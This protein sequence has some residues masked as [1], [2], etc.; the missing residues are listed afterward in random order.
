MR[1]RIV[2]ALVLALVFFLARGASAQVNAEALRSTLRTNP[3]FLWLQSA[4]NGNAGNT[5]TI[6]YSGAAFG[7]LTAVPHLAF[8]RAAVDFG[9][10]SGTTNIA[11]MMAHARYNYD[12]TE[13]IALEALAQVQRDRF[14][15][16]SLRDLYGGGLR[17]ALYRSKENEVFSGTTYL[18]EH[19]IIGDVPGSEGNN[20]I[21]HRS[22]DYFGVNLSLT[23]IVTASSVIYAQPR[24]DRPLDFRIL[25][26]TVVTFTITK[27]LSA[28]VSGT[29][30]YD[31]RPP[32]G[33]HTYDL[34]IKNS[35]IF[36]LQ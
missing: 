23:P 28:G 8:A 35:L 22:S 29:V 4:L 26:D 25:S 5:S 27:L 16:L 1:A 24:F 3:R 2:S 18:L 13:V 33:V 31:N 11:R 20:N 21:W 9:A 32:A 7:G 14:R 30:W 36:K 15:R 19:E 17:F 12:V 34:A 10:A 6:T